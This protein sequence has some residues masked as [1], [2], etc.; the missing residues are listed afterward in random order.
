[1]AQ[2]ND[3]GGYVVK[4]GDTPASIIRNTGL[5]YA[6][7]ARLGQFR[8]GQVLKR[9]STLPYNQQSALSVA[10]TA[11][12]AP[13]P[14][15]Q[16]PPYAGYSLTHYVPPPAPAG[17]GY[18]SATNQLRATTGQQPIMSPSARAILDQATDRRAQEQQLYDQQQAYQAAY[19]AQHPNEVRN[20]TDPA[21]PV[22]LLQQQL[23]TNYN[24]GLPPP[25]TIV[26]SDV[27]RRTY[28]RQTVAAQMR[29]LGYVEKG[30]GVYVLINSPGA[31][32]GGGGGGSGGGGYT[33]KSWGGGGG[34]GG[35]PA[36]SDHRIGTQYAQ[37]GSI[38]GNAGPGQYSGGGS[39]TGRSTG[40]YNP[41]AIGAINWRI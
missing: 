31:S 10:N 14:Q 6:A 1:V 32:S 20:R 15:M 40:Y 33:V 41:N 17:T 37:Q 26:L 11:P 28:N 5:S 16:A 3:G 39:R 13:P 12:G 38:G 35:S 34:G 25:P 29:A 18:W 8:P 7:L 24:L 21:H 30:D 2:Y 36:E 4:R 23:T 27:A 19:W 9:S 22:Y